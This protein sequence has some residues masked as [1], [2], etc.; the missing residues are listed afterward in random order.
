[1][2]VA[3]CGGSASS[4][5]SPIVT[6]T[7]GKSEAIVWYAGGSKLIGLDGDTGK[8]II[9]VDGVGMMNKWQAPIVAKGRVYVA[10]ASQLYAFVL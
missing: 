7:D 10:G 1:V 2:S 6:T 4:T 5:G 9:S 8:E 3:W